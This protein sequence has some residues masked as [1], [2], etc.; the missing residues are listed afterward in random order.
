MEYN[1]L[2]DLNDIA[3]EREDYKTLYETTVCE[4]FG[5]ERDDLELMAERWEKAKSPKTPTDITEMESAPRG[6]AAEREWVQQAAAE[7]GDDD[8]G[9]NLGIKSDRAP[10][11]G[12]VVVL[13]SGIGHVTDVEAQDRMVSI[14]DRAT[15]IEKI[16]DFD[17]LLGPKNV[18]G[19]L[20]WQ[21][22]PKAVPKN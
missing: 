4:L 22:N 10:E 17:A 15:G 19:K 7:R 8:Q 2:S 11:V 12:N 13:A 1:L 16:F 20:A 5:F 18:N 6:R 9:P 21:L 14:K 3:K